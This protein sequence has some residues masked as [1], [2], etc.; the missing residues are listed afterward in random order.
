MLENL[1]QTFGILGSLAVAL[2]IFLLIIFW[3]AGIAGITSNNKQDGAIGK[4]I[5]CVLF[6]PYPIIWL[7]T[8]MSRQYKAMKQE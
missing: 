2:V 4:L 7:I 3:V 8:D 5:L 6:P 1:Y